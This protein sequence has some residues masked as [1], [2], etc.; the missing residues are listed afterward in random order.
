MPK[1]ENVKIG[2][3]QMDVHAA[4]VKTEIGGIH[5]SFLHSFLSLPTCLEIIS[6]VRDNRASHVWISTLS[7]HGVGS[8]IG[9]VW[10]SDPLSRKLHPSQMRLARIIFT[11][12]NRKSLEGRLRRV[13]SHC[14]QSSCKFQHV[15]FVLRDFVWVWC[16]PSNDTHWQHLPSNPWDSVKV[17]KLK[18]D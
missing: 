15:T 3:A 2:H 9:L 11:W 17:V 18:P 13:L 16:H 4:N 6:E 8:Y 12:I 1:T 7:A 5:C 14:S 10:L